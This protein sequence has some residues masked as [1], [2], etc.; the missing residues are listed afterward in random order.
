MMGYLMVNLM[1]FPLY[2]VYPC[3]I[4]LLFFVFYAI[5]PNAIDMM[6]TVE[7]GGKG[8]LLGLRLGL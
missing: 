7:L 6:K 4:I 3:D 8:A 2:Q 5:A 1:I